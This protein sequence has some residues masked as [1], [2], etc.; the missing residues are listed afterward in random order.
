MTEQW[1]EL[2]E[3]IIELRDNDGNGTQQEVCKFLANL[4]NVLEKQ[5]KEPKTKW[6]PASTPPKQDGKYLVLTHYFDCDN[7][8]ILSYANNLYEVDDFD[9]YYAEER[10]GWYEYDSEYGYCECN[11]VVAWRELPEPYKESRK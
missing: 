2:K 9:F 10:G 7:I 8:E 11:G 6:T 1:N 3:T 4:M 5:L